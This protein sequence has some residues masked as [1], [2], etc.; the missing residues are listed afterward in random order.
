MMEKQKNKIFDFSQESDSISKEDLESEGWK[1]FQDRMNIPPA[2]ELLPEDEEDRA[3]E[4]N[5][6]DVTIIL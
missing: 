1:A 4:E 3:Y 6:V 2:F 5:G